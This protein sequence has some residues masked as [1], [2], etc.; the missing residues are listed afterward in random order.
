MTPPDDRWPPPPPPPGSESGERS[1][2]A[3]VPSETVPHD[4]VPSDPKPAADP[5][6]VVEDDDAGAEE[7]LYDGPPPEAWSSSSVGSATGPDADDSAT[8]AEASPAAGGTPPA[9]RPA[10]SPGLALTL[11]GC[12]GC[13]ASSQLEGHRGG[14]IECEICRQS[15]DAWVYP[16]LDEPPPRVLRLHEAGPEGATPCGLHPGNA[17]THDCSR[18]GLLICT[19]C[20]I[21]VGEQ[22]LCPACFERQQEAGELPSL[23]RRELDY[24]S[25]ATA[26]AV[27][28]FVTCL[29][30]GILFGPATLVLTA[31]AARQERRWGQRPSWAWLGAVALVG[32]IQLGLGVAFGVMVFLGIAEGAA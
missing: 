17:A 13:G 12:P 3:S 1:E 27:L 7:T 21:E 9:P 22:V 6:R 30:F 23:S 8:P 19:L 25:M 29:V 15:Y 31:L 4:P 26:S 11:Y 18:C 5:L 2:P 28:G 20:R 16:E 10:G 24:R 32:L 14:T